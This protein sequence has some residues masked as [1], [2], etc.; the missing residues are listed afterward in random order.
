MLNAEHELTKWA[1]VLDHKNLPAI[2]DPYRKAVTAKLLEQTEV[3]T[4]NDSRYL[5]EATGQVTT[6]SVATYD[7]VLISLVR[8]AMPNL[9]AYDVAGVQ[10]LQL[11]T[12]LIFAMKARRESTA[13]AAITT[14]DAEILFSE[15]NT[16]FS[17]GD[18]TGPTSSDPFD[19]DLSLYSPTTGVSTATG[20]GDILGR[21]GFTIEKATVTAV[22][23]QLAS[24]YTMEIAH[25]L[26]RVHGLDAESE[27]A[28]ILTTEILSEMNREV[29]RNIN[30]K[31]ILGAQQSGLTTAG[32][33][34]LSTDADGRW[35]VEKFK[36]LIF[37]IEL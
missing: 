12:G 7:P 20:E 28:N 16:G 19:A 24:E 2:R 37:Q 26:Q 11:P 25:D 22:T 18:A 29:V 10:P 36:S 27:L 14:A 31:A 13:S 30:V 23:R 33:F 15:S 6:G 9:I 8:R 4:R 17:A 34:D 32:T 3:E 21:A 1:E 5:A 35:A